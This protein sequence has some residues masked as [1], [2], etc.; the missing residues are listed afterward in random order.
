MLHNMSVNKYCKFFMFFTIM[1][2]LFLLS[3]SVHLDL[4]TDD[5]YFSTITQNV[6]I[7]DQLISRYQVWTGRIPLEAIMLY[8]INYSFFWK[9]AVPACLLLLS[10]SISRL[11]CKKV[12]L[13][14]TFM[15][16]LLLFMIPSMINTNA[17]WW[18]TGFYIYLLPVSLATYALSFL[19]AD[20][21]HKIEFFLVCLTTCIFAYTEQVGIYFLFIAFIIFCI[22]KRARS[23]KNFCVYIL[24]CINFLILIT[25]P[26]NYI[27]FSQEIWRCFP[28][29]SYYSFIQ[30]LCFGFDKLHQI[31]VFYWNIPLVA[32]ICILVVLYALYGVKSLASHISI[33]TVIGY[34]SFSLLQW[35]GRSFPQ[36]GNNF[37]NTNLLNAE[38]WAS[39][40]MYVSYFFVMMVVISLIIL[41]I[42]TLKNNLVLL[43]VL[44]LFLLGIF[45]TLLIGFSPTIYVSNFRV[46]YVFEVCCIINFLLLMH[47]LFQI[48]QQNQ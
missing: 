37:L 9:I 17:A 14:Y 40:S 5:H 4:V 18:V 45:D 41:M 42:S 26:G 3:L 15:A 11:V 43:M 34:V 8:T 30:K 48:N 25:A 12:T 13:L 1:L 23:Y 47:Y 10:T 44:S 19:L 31:F 24:T 20:Q 35:N 28:D 33:G 32:F 2:L 46:D 27:R 22:Y 7:I 16:L 29:Y 39:A 6:N 21:Q 38:K 36:F